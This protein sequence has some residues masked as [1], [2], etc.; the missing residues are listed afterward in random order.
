MKK[1]YLILLLPSLTVCS[2]NPF[3]SALIGAFQSWQRF[4]QQNPHIAVGVKHAAIEAVQ[5]GVQNM[6]ESSDQQKRQ[7][8]YDIHRLHQERLQLEAD[9]KAAVENA[10]RAQEEARRTEI[11]LGQQL[12]RCLNDNFHA[13][14]NSHGFPQR[15]SSPA[16]RYAAINEMAT[17]QLIGKH[18]KRRESAKQQQ[19]FRV[20]S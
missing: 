1:L 19:Q 18:R 11:L 4:E 20:L 6:R 15:C 8:L 14:E 16:R 17:D 7:E 12:D 3:V 10:K 2:D 13:T 9:Q 5:N